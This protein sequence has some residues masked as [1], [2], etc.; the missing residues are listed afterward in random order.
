MCPSDSPDAG[1][2]APEIVA[3]AQRETM[4]D[5]TSYVSLGSAPLT[6]TSKSTVNGPAT[7]SV[8]VPSSSEIFAFLLP[9]MVKT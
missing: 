7:L 4:F 6:S 9:S 3:V 5:K 2:D 1:A 8:A